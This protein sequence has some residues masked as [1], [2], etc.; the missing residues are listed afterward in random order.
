MDNSGDVIHWR[1][2]ALESEDHFGKCTIVNCSGRKIQGTGYQLVGM[3]GRNV[4][5]L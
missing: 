3:R 4:G 2:S 5:R 1:E